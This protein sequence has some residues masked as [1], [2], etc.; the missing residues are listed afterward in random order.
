MHAHDAQHV[1]S[2]REFA[3]RLS[4]EIT[5]SPLLFNRGDIFSNNRCPERLLIQVQNVVLTIVEHY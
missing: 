4:F 1:S 2:L 3:H 5:F